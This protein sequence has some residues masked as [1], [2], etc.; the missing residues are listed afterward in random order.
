MSKYRVFYDKEKTL[1]I[2]PNDNSYTYSSDNVIVG[3]IREICIYL[4]TIGVDCT[5]LQE[6][7]DAEAGSQSYQYIIIP[8]SMV[9]LLT[10]MVGLVEDILPHLSFDVVLETTEITNRKGEVKKVKS[11]VINMT[12]C[13]IIEWEEGDDV[14]LQ[15]IVDNWNSENASKQITFNCRFETLQK[16]ESFRAEQSWI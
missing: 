1:G 13:A 14:L 16:L 12:P 3:T 9:P 6:Y 5:A 8:S 4:R 11:K 10:D 15:G 2:V 7:E